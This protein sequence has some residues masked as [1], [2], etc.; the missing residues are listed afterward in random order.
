MSGY[1]MEDIETSF[2][3]LPTYIC[4]LNSN[5]IRTFVD[6]SVGLSPSRRDLYLNKHYVGFMPGRIILLLI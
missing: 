6:I 5:S 3:L 1:N 2:N 4:N